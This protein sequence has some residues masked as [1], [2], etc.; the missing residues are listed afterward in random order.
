MYSPQFANSGTGAVV[1]EALWDD[2]FS[3]AFVRHPYDR[4]A[5][6]YAWQRDAV[7]RAAPDAPVWS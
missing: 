1:G 7:G 2:S 6:F 4:L 3:F 5:S